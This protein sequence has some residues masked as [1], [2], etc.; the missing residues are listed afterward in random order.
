M[1]RHYWVGLLGFT[2]PARPF[3]RA[4]LYLDC[5]DFSSPRTE[6]SEVRPS[7]PAGAAKP[8]NLPSDVAWGSADGPASTETLRRNARP[9]RKDRSVWGWEPGSGPWS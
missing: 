2:P 6:A 3:N 9:T 4:A 5:G 8:P 7:E 1:A